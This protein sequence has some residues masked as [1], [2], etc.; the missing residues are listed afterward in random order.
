M[1]AA[2]AMPL[3]R[4]AF[5]TA[6]GETGSAPACT[7][8]PSNRVVCT[9]ASPKMPRATAA[10][11]AVT[12]RAAERPIAPAS[13]TPSGRS[14]RTSVHITPVGV[15][16]DEATAVV[17]AASI[18]ARLAGSA[19]V[20]PSRASSRSAAPAGTRPDCSRAPSEMRTSETTAPPFCARPVMS[21][22]RTWRPSS[23]A[24]AAMTAA[25]MTTPVPPTPVTRTFQLRP[26][27]R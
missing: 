27:P 23:R 12:A 13:A 9:V 8:A 17:R 20:S 2:T 22:P 10:A 5:S 19:D 4:K 11:S 21:T 26:A 1:L 18:T 15:E 6:A 3:L 24:A 16:V 7:A 25:N 14:A